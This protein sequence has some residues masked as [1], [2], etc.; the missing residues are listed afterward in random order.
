MEG[1]QHISAVYG[2]PH[3]TMQFPT[4]WDRGPEKEER[5]SIIIA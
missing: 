4:S 5:V 1:Q 2:V 3:L